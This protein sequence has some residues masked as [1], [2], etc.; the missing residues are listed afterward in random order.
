ML[1]R[2]ANSIVSGIGEV[3]G[4]VAIDGFSLAFNEG[5]VNFNAGRITIDFDAINFDASELMRSLVPL[6]WKESPQC[7]VG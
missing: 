4:I 1:G 6:M 5:V 2:A 7:I 3:V